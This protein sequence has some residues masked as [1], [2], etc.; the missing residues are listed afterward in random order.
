[1]RSGIL[2]FVISAATFF[3][4]PT[5]AA[6]RCP[7]LLYAS[8]FDRAPMAGS[9]DAVL[10]AVQ[11]GAPIRIGWGLDFDND[12]TSDLSHWANADFI[13]VFEGEVFGQ[14]RAIQ[15]QRPIRGE[16]TISL[17]EG[18]E[19]RGS[20]GTNGMME[21]AFSNDRDVPTNVPTQILW[22]EDRPA[23]PRWQAVFK[24]GVNGEVLDGDI[25]LLIAAIRAGQ[26]IQ[27]GWGLS[28]EQNGE[29]ISVEHLISPDFLTI[30]NE[31]HVVAQLPEH[32]A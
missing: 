15:R 5:H 2:V 26:P 25:T 8:G 21:G 20:F 16:A 32:I 7:H 19:W 11:R 14:V 23:A 4:S 22:C 1:M 18:V 28:A 27:I 3:C 30:T 12:G 31:Q 6:D 13:S 24:S 9:K 10:E 29:P 17:I